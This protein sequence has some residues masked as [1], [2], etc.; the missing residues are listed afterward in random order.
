MTFWDVINFGLRVSGAFVG[1]VLTAW[2]LHWWRQWQA[3]H[4]P[5]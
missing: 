3:K 5:K 1:M 2:L 4:P